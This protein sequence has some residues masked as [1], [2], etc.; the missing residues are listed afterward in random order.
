MTALQLAI[1]R[2]NPPTQAE[3]AR[4]IG[5]KPQQVNRWVKGGK[6]LPSVHVLIVEQATGIS[7][8]VLRPDVYGASQ[9][10]QGGNG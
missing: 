3:L 9:Q 8:H 1:S 6:K 5:R 2:L 10:G 4:V 7:R